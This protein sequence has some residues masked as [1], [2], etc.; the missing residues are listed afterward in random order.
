MPE[1]SSE[2][3]RLR[4]PWPNDMRTYDSAALVGV[5]VQRVPAGYLAMAGL[6]ENSTNIYWYFF[7]P[8]IP[9][10]AGTFFSSPL[11]VTWAEL[12]RL[13]LGHLEEG[14]DNATNV[15]L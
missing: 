8:S 2:P 5:T 4:W 11:A 13:A 6:E 12:H 9:R 3:A 15:V 14:I 10:R 1:L 7:R